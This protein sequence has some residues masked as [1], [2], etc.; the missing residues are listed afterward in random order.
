MVRVGSMLGDFRSLLASSCS[1]YD[2]RASLGKR[3]AARLRSICLLPCLDSAF[4]T[5][6]VMNPITRSVMTTLPLGQVKRGC[7]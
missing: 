5:L 6:R 4:I 3:K 7:R 2:P 1:W